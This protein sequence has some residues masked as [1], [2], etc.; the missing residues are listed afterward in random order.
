MMLFQILTLVTWL[1]FVATYGK[2]GII[3]GGENMRKGCVVLDSS[4][5][6]NSR[7]QSTDEKKNRRRYLRELKKQNIDK[8]K[9]CEGKTYGAGAF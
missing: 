9:V 7:C 1:P 5:I 4:W 3:A 8:S 6:S 2:L